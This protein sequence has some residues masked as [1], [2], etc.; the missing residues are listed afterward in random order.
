LI[1]STEVDTEGGV[2]FVPV[3][4]TVQDPAADGAV[5]RPAAV[6]VPQVADQVTLT[7]A[8]NCTVAFVTTV[9]FI[10]AME[11]GV[12]SALLDPDNAT[13]CGLPFA[14][15]EIVNVAARD[16]DAVGLNAMPIVQLVDP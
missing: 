5:N 4:V 6:I 13:W 8:E 14:E 16:P 1:T 12:A 11:R 10:G 2:V 3:A 9:G 7:F 15:S